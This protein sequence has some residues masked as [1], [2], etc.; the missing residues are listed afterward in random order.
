MSRFLVERWIAKGDKSRV[1]ESIE[2]GTHIGDF[3]N[4]G[5][6]RKRVNY[7]FLDKKDDEYLRSGKEYKTKIEYK[8]GNEESR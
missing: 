4:S 2:S 6:D 7:L 8:S 3:I 5:V 1:L